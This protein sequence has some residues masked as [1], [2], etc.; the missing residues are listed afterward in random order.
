MC[1]NHTKKYEVIEMYFHDILW[2]TQPTDM[3]V[4]VCVYGAGHTIRPF[5]LPQNYYRVCETVKYRNSGADFQGQGHWILRNMIHTSQSFNAIMF[6]CVLYGTIS[7]QC[8]ILSLI[9]NTC[10]LWKIKDI[11]WG[12]IGICESM[13]GRTAL[14]KVQCY[15]VVKTRFEG[16]VQEEYK[17]AQYFL[18]FRNRISST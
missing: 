9:T 13:F 4:C 1:E 10:S 8:L 6:I 2:L 18:T 3:C 11:I 5:T 16:F 14:N 12:T 17:I 7:Y 15:R